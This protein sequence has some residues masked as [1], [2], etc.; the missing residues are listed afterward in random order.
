[1]NLNTSNHPLNTQ[2]I[3]HCKM[4]I[5][6]VLA[7]AAVIG[8]NNAAQ[9]LTFNFTF[10]DAT[11]L[12]VRSVF[13]D[14]GDAWSKQF[15]D[16]VAI[17][18]FVDYGK[19]PPNV[20]AGSR[21]G[22]TRVKYSEFLTKLRQD[23]SSQEGAKYISQDYDDARALSKLQTSATFKYLRSNSG[24]SIQ[25]T[26]DTNWLT[27][28]NAKTLG[29]INQNNSDYNN[30]DASIRI[31]NNA[32][33]HYDTNVAA[34]SVK[35][36][37][38]SVATHE[39]GHALGVISGGDAFQVSSQNLNNVTP[40]DLFRYSKLSA[41][42]KIPDWTM[43]ETFFSLDGGSNSLGGLS[44]G[45]NIDGFQAGH[46]KNGESRGVMSPFLN[47][48]ERVGISELDRRLLDAVGWDYA[49]QLSKNVVAV[50]G[51]INW[52]TSNP[53]LSLLEN[54]LKAHLS[55][56]MENLRQERDAIRAQDSSVWSELNA[57]A[58][59][60]LQK[61][62]QGI[63]ET[64]NQIRGNRSDPNKRM[65]E[66]LKG[67][68]IYLYALADLNKV[69][70]DKLQVP[71][72]AQTS[73]WLN[74]SSEQLKNNLEKATQSQIRSL[75]V[76][77]STA[78]GSQPKVKEALRLLYL[79]T[80]GNQY[81]SEIELNTALAKLLDSASPDAGLGRTRTV[82]YWQTGDTNSN[83]E[84]T[85]EFAFYEYGSAEH[86]HGSAAHENTSLP[87]TTWTSGVLGLLGLFGIGLLKRTSKRK[88]I[89]H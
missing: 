29:I 46:W 20:L 69:Y 33:W 54:L 47:T 7:F 65:E 16:D 62:Q 39:I 2:P 12:S 61:R 58:G 59:E 68:S 49:P 41:A 79:Q 88:G 21:P 24:G 10:S 4:M 25:V 76:K 75:A 78:S 34:P 60:E 89:A 71:L 38:L 80:H 6:L 36:D 19:L 1:M 86:E 40:M 30:F 26:G 77:L 84:N 5:P 11:P 74:G 82:R 55:I 56:E 45:V 64:L 8:S 31:S 43:G 50:M 3:K 63:Q 35:H 14:A 32:P 87:A 83:F 70:G 81:P 53:D 28:A 52:N 9:A 67:A 57:K 48:G 51:G 37:L 27:R 85:G 44:R 66:A 42:L 15:T 73:N 18:I 22:M 13:W 17:N 72:A 23:K